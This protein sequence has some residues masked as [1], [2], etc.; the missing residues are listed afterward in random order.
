MDFGQI[1]STIVNYSSLEEACKNAG[2]VLIEAISELLKQDILLAP[3][4]PSF[5]EYAE[6]YD[7]VLYVWEA[8]VEVVPSSPPTLKPCDLTLVK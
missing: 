2:Q 7:D 8:W 1:S 5:T 3:P 4:S 6:D